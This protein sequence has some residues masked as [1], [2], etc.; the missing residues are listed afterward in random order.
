MCSY[1]LDYPRTW[2]HISSVFLTRWVWNSFRKNVILNSS[3]SL[4]F[5]VLKAAGNGCRVMLV[6][7]DLC[8]RNT[9]TNGWCNTSVMRRNCY[10]IGS[11][12]VIPSYFKEKQSKKR[13]SGV[14]SCCLSWEMWLFW[15]TCG[16]G[17][18]QGLLS[19]LNNLKSL[20]RKK[21]GYAACKL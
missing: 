15:T 3:K 5:L 19:L 20:F 8:A 14:V 17:R 2:I 1:K 4:I 6:F 21:K 16:E 10:S 12:F 18:Y 11:S 9:W 13:S 7:A